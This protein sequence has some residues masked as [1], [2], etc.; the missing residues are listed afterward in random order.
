MTFYFL[1]LF[2]LYFFLLIVLRIGWS[3]ALIQVEKQPDHIFFISVII[4]VRNEAKNIDTVLL[5]LSQ[6]HYPPSHIE[7]I[8]VDDNSTD[9]SINRAD[10]H[11]AHF[12]GMT[13]LSLG[14][15]GKGKKKALT[16]G[17]SI[18]RGEII[19]TT[20][21]DCVLPPDWLTSINSF[22]Q[23]NHVAMA[24]GMVAVGEQADYFSRWQA[25]EF[26]SIIGTSTA[27]LGVK[28]PTDEQWA[29][30]CRFERKYFSKCG[31]MKATTI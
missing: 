10:Q 30:T 29:P 21:A 4:P 9:D 6:Q 24:V 18:A 15:S 7:V 31:D 2:T 8:V 13:V 3:R 28:H 27:A 14:A 25:M 20:D 17:I 26:A 23:D 16:Q 19:A 1:I 12:K 22:F 11:R 5:S